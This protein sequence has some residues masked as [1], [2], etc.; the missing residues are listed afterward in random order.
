[1]RRSSQRVLA[2]A[3]IVGL[4]AIA[5]CKPTAPPASLALT[6]V[7]V[8]DVETGA[9]LRD[10]TI[11][12]DD[13]VIR[14]VSS[15]AEAA[16]AIGAGTRVIDGARRYAIP[17]LWDM[18]VHF[19]TGPGADVSRSDLIRENRA[20]LPQYVGYG[21]TAVRDCGGDMP[22]AVLAWRKQIADGTLIGPRIFT[23]LRKLD[24]P[25]P[26]RGGREVSTQG[27]VAVAS[28]AEAAAAVERLVAAGADF[29]KLNDF[30]ID[31]AT[32][33]A[34]LAAAKARG[35]P[36]AGHVPFQM[37]LDDVI[38]AGIGSIEH[39][40]HLLKA[41]FPDDRAF[42]ADLARA[43]AAG[44]IEPFPDLIAR[45]AARA[46]HDRARVVLRR[47]ASR[48]V[49]LTPTALMLAQVVSDVG[50]AGHDG[51]ERLAQVPLS[52]RASFE[53]RVGDAASRS[54]EEVASHVHA[55]AVARELV[56]I[57]AQEGVTILAG[58]DTGA[59]NSFMYP[60]F[61]LHAELEELVAAGLSPLEALQAAT[62]RGAQ[63]FGASA[64]YGT[65]AAGKAAD[66]VILE[67]NPLADIANTRSIAGVALSGVYFDAAALERLRT[68]DLQ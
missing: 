65:I 41:A 45:L 28:P 35:M 26:S 67:G 7:A 23:S 6:D 5:A 20:L 27:S 24:G 55:A 43:I 3:I 14:S 21:V 63:W 48:G 50:T 40:D 58:T 57:A 19:R 4:T 22:E 32:Y 33:F 60:G 10:R 51:D 36:T 2:V 8:V 61:T 66:I 59:G 12:V 52:I 46:D 34:V 38:E 31:D 1:M 18:H 62:I 64:R 30:W 47:M 56:G 53:Q 16:A 25:P 44:E 68:L 13:G 37:P 29:I 54:P 11:L 15:A 42:S 39:D 49:A 9:V 17:G